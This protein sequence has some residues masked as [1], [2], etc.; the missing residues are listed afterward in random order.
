MSLISTVYASKFRI[1]PI[2]KQTLSMVLPTPEDFKRRGKKRRHRKKK[3][4]TSRFERE[5]ELQRW[6][7]L[8]GCMTEYMQ[9]RKKRRARHAK[10]DNV[11]RGSCSAKPQAKR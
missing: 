11:A 4:F 9:W 6:A 7:K 1:E 5:L 10:F 3:H 8:C 2:N